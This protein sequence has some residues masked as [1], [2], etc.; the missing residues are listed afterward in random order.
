MLTTGILMLGKMSVGVRRM[1]IGARSNSSSETT[2]K[3]YG[4]LNASRTIH[5]IFSGRVPLG[6]CSVA[7]QQRS[8]IRNFDVQVYGTCRV[9]TGF[10]FVPSQTRVLYWIE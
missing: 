7:D 10:I 9:A 5:I 2:T 1:T 8:R 4:R 6:A 3:V